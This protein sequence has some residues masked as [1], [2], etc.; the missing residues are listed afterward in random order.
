MGL[1]ITDLGQR[2]ELWFKITSLSDLGKGRLWG[3]LLT[4]CSYLGGVIGKGVGLFEEVYSETM[5][6]TQCKLHQGKFYRY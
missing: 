3:E 4:A 1:P 2:E 6:G 5:T